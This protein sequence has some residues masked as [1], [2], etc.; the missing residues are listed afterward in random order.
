MQATHGTSGMT[1]PA[2][3]MVTKERQNGDLNMMDNSLASILDK[4]LTKGIRVL[5]QTNFIG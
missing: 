1:I 5:C 2:L 4:I 3:E